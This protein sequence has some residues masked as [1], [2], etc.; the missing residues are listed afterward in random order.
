MTLEKVDI[1]E[2]M[3]EVAEGKLTRL[4]LATIQPVKINWLEAHVK[5]LELACGDIT[6]FEEAFLFKIQ[7]ELE[8]PQNAELLKRWN[9]AIAINKKVRMQL[10][11]H[12]ALRVLERYQNLSSTSSAADV[13]YARAVL[14][15][16]NTDREKDVKRPD[17]KEDEYDEAEK[18]MGRE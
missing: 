1:H 2:V 11:T 5:E 15:M 7:H 17:E 12:K 10:I 3:H 13:S 16:C 8:H 9:K 14:F 18:S 6:S 4:P